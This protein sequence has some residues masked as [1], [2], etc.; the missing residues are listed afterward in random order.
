MRIS[1]SLINISFFVDF[2]LECDFL[3]FR[4]IYVLGFQIMQFE[5]NAIKKLI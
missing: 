2:R 4:K 5:I 1:I 3:I